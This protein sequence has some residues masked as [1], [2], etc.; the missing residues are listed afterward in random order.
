MVSPTRKL[1]IPSFNCAFSND[2]MMF[3]VNLPA[4]ISILK[5]Q[6]SNHKRMPNISLLLKIGHCSLLVIWCSLSLSRFQLSLQFFQDLPVFLGQIS[7][8]EEVRPS[9]ESSLKR[10]TPPPLLDPSVISGEKH[11]RNFLAAEFHRPRIVRMVE[12][13]VTKRIAVSRLFI[14]EDPGQESDRRIDHHERCE[15][16]AGEHIIP[17]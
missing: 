14:A 3:M 12:Q 6:I 1:G 8:L 2:C 16:A 5:F 9:Q 15:L 7:I 17:D 10:L 13:P 4:Y 11:L